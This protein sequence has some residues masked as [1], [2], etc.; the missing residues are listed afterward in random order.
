[1]VMISIGARAYYL[2]QIL[3]DWSDEPARKILEMI[4]PAMTP[5]YSRLLVHERVVLEGQL[6]PQVTALD[7]AVMVCLSGHE[8][9]ESMWR[10]LLQSA[11]FEIIK[12]WVSPLMTACIIEAELASTSSI[13]K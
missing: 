1:M 9:T 5:G 12:I 2:R 7:M 11:G 13:D 4:K 8:R 6:N 10:A 3:H